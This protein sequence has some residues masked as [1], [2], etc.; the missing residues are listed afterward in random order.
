ML[1]VAFQGEG[2]GI[3]ITYRFDGKLFNLSKLQAKSKVQTSVLDEFPFAD[4]TAKGALTE[5]KMQMCGSSIWFMWQIWSH[6]QHQKG[7][8]GIT[9]ST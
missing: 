5:E 1:T 9:A 7:W 8:G 2:N 4:D 6:N 3:P